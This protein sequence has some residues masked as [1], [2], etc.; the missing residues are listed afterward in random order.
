MRFGGQSGFVSRDAEF[1]SVKGDE[2]RP[3]SVLM[4]AAIRDLINAPE[5]QAAFQRLLGNGSGST[6]NLNNAIQPC[7]DGL[8]QAFIIG[9][10]F[11]GNDPVCQV[12][13]D[14]IC[15]AKGFAPCWSRQPARQGARSLAIK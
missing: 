11:I 6:I 15:Y 8:A 7:P 5:D 3:L 14:E 2:E 10:D 1:E 4:L 12:L 13:D 9:D